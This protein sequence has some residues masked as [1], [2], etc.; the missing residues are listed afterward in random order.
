MLDPL[1]LLMKTTNTAQYAAEEANNS[2]RFACVKSD[3]DTEN[4]NVN[5]TRIPTASNVGF[6]FPMLVNLYIATIGRTSRMK[7][8]IVIIMPTRVRIARGE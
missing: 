1:K 7:I 5:T 6:R 2:C 8:I 4:N 3:I